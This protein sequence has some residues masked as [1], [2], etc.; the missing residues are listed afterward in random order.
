MS[1]MPAGADAQATSSGPA[2]LWSEQRIAAALARQIFID[3]S[4]VVV[5]NCNWTGH[6]CDLLIVTRRLR[7][8]DVEIKISR[9]DLRVD[10][11][12]D[13]WYHNWD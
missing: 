13:K 6:E 10:A 5:P 9:A 1:R 12:K 7:V 4:V 8:I 3:D 2:Q 11:C